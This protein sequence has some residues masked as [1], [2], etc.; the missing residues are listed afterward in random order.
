[1]ADWEWN[2]GIGITFGLVA[3]ALT[4]FLIVA[5]QY[6][7]F[8]RF[9]PLRLLGAAA[10]SIYAT[11]LIAYTL[12]P[13]PDSTA[14][15][16]APTL[17]IV[18]FHSVGDILKVTVG[19]GIVATLTSAAMLQVV[20]NV[21][22]FVPLGVIVRGFF[23]RRLP[24]TVLVGLATSV[25]IEAT[26]Y[27]AIWG[28]YSCAYRVADIDDVITNTL[29]ALVGAL[30]GPWLLRWMPRERALLAARAT[31]RPVTVWR[32]WLGMAIDLAL[33]SAIGSALVVPYRLVLIA[34]G[35]SVGDHPDPVEA[36][37]GALVPAL[38]V[39]VLPSLRKSGASLGQSA[40]WLQPHWGRTPSAA[41]RLGRAA[42]V[43]GL[44]GVLVFVSRLDTAAAGVAGTLG[45]L[46]LVAAFVAVP[47]SHGAGLSALVSRAVMRDEREP[48]VS[49]PPR[50]P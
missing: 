9:T 37:L 40:V 50:L 21:L 44:Y 24:T 17:E 6:R 41:R 36:A 39:F 48:A 28:I 12:L 43:G 46:L 8:G 35:R 13:L 29:G 26:Q 33:F 3:F 11:T 18:P 1:M 19:D 23:S 16:C 14:K 38:L 2:A 42:S 47:L 4:F 22:L 45:T 20:F 49:E 10:V 34:L 15:V 7:R 27:T 25:L 31:P 5:V 30:L 32:R